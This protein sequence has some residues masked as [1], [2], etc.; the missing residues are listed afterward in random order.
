MRSLIVAMML[1]LIP[2]AGFCEPAKFGS[3]FVDSAADKDTLYAATLNDSG[4]LLGIYCFISS[5]DC[6]YAIGMDSACVSESTYPTLANAD[7]GTSIHH[8]YCDKSVGSNYRYYFKNFD[9]IELSVTTAKRIGFAI[10]LQGDQF[11]VVRFDLDGASKAISFMKSL[12]RD[13]H[14]ESTGTRKNT[15]NKYL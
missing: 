1:M 6:L 3:W 10:P 2:V 9:D 8:L 14:N 12:L 13:L 11:K 15:K 4:S 7:N 5:A